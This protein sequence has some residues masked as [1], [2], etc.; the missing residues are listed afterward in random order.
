M[1][2]KGVKTQKKKCYISME[3]KGGKTRHGSKPQYEGVNV[4]KDEGG[5]EGNKERR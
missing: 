4:Q 3:M 5:D 2:K 1:R